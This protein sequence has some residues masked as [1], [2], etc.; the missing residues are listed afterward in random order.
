M[1]VNLEQV[2]DKGMKM[3]MMETGGFLALQVH[4]II[5]SL[6]LIGTTSFNLWLWYMR[7]RVKL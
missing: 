6:V 7:K 3:L 4:W 2:Y 1:G 5:G